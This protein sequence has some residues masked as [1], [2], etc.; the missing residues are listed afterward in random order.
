ME[1]VEKCVYYPSGWWMLKMF[2]LTIVIPVGT[3][4]AHTHDHKFV[5]DVF[6]CFILVKLYFVC[7]LRCQLCIRGSAENNIVLTMLI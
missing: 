4:Y 6:H 2:M 5:V 7:I 1:C 3:L